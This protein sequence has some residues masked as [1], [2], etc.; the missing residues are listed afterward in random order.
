MRLNKKETDDIIKAVGF[1][2]AKNEAAELRLYGSRVDDKAKGGDID[3]LLIVAN[4]EFAAKLIYN[5]PEILV[6]IK[7]LLGERRIDLKITIATELSK[8]PFLKM[9]FPTSIL[10]NKF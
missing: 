3:L 1:F 2:V 8:D 5:K 4:K 7:K 6:A 9:I 10:L